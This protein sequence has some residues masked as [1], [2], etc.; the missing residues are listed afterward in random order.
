MVKFGKFNTLP[1]GS[2]VTYGS[3]TT[4]QMSTRPPIVRILDMLEHPNLLR[5]ILFRLFG[6]KECSHYLTI[7]DGS[8]FRV[9]KILD[10]C[11][12][13]YYDFGIDK[14]NYFCFDTP[15]VSHMRLIQ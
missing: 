12:V 10:D 1:G 3:S 2:S 9:R 7:Q 14:T 11:G 8:P 6:V 13:Q 5:R 15:A 4:V